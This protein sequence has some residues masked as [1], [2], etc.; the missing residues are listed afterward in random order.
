M[1]KGERR[2]PKKVSVHR[3]FFGFGCDL[4][5]ICI[6]FS[7]VNHYSSIILPRNFKVFCP[8]FKKSRKSSN[9]Y[10]D[11]KNPP[12]PDVFLQKMCRFPWLIPP[13][14]PP[15]FPGQLAGWEVFIDSGCQHVIAT[16]RRGVDDDGRPRMIWKSPYVFER[17]VLVW[18]QK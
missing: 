1:Q 10:R 11:I 5:V 7:H 2:S 6:W 4:H 15:P 14:F 12:W 16:D 3:W 17:E 18:F 13:R 8:T 9:K